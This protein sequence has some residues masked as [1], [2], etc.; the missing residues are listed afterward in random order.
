MIGRMMTPVEGMRADRAQRAKR[1]RANT[2][3]SPPERIRPVA[4]R[5]AGAAGDPP[6]GDVGT[7]R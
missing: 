1:A 4:D 2:P 7:G 5:G 6:M 3:G